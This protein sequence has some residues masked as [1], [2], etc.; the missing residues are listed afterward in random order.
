M[1]D[2]YIRR[3]NTG[4]GRAGFDVARLRAWFDLAPDER[5]FLAGILAIAVIGLT[6]RYLHLRKEKPAPYPPESGPAETRENR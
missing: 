3:V 4:E 6:A 1:A 2:L 5:R